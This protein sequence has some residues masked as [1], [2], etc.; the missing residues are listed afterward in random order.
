VIVDWAK[1]HRRPRLAIMRGTGSERR[2]TSDLGLPDVLPCDECERKRPL[3]DNER[4]PDCLTYP[5]FRALDETGH[6]PGCSR[7]EELKEV[8]DG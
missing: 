6:W 8:S 1:Y 5:V 2:L 7:V 4:H 3:W